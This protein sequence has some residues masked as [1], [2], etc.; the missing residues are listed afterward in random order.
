[1][2]KE[3]KFS[4]TEQNALKLAEH[5]HKGQKRLGG[6]DYIT[7]PIDVAKLLYNYQLR[8]KYVF[9]A[10]CHDLLEDTDVKEEE[11]LET[12]GRFTLNAVKLLTKRRK[13]DPDKEVDM[14]AYLAAIRK[15]D[16]AYQVKVADRTM[17]LWSLREVDL[18]FREKYLKETEK[19]YLDFA[20]DSILYGELKLAYETLKT[21]TN[22]M[23]CLHIPVEIEEIIDDIPDDDSVLLYGFNYDYEEI[24]PLLCEFLREDLRYLKKKNIEDSPALFTGLLKVYG[25]SYSEVARYSG[26]EEYDE[27]KIKDPEEMSPAS[28]SIIYPYDEPPKPFALIT[29]VVQGVGKVFDVENDEN[30]VRLIEVYLKVLGPVVAVALDEEQFHDVEPGEVISG[31]FYLCADPVNKTI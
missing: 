31:V 19:F 24:F 25:Y 13:N 9:T 14:N 2:S 8:G 22:I 6:E 1:M 10:F 29:G 17:N 18:E 12:C 15:D 28:Q 4:P 21:E 3:I 27:E 23:K 16:V 20:K 11:I 26:T 5:Y 7:H 30:E